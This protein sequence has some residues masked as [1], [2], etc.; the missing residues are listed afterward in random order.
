[1]HRSLLALALCAGCPT[2]DPSDSGDTGSTIDGCH[3]D[4]PVEGTP[5]DRTMTASDAGVDTLATDVDNLG[6]ALLTSMDDVP[7]NGAFSALSVMGMFS[8]LMP[9]TDGTVASDLEAVLQ[10]SQSPDAHHTALSGVL[11]E[12]DDADRGWGYEWGAGFWH[13]PSLTIGSDWSDE[14]GALYGVAP[15]PLD[16]QQDG[17]AARQLLNGWVEQHTRCLIPEFYPP[18]YDFSS[19]VHV[20]IHAMAIEALWEEPF[21][22]AF[23]T[24]RSFTLA[25]GSTVTVPTMESE[26][27]QGAEG[28]VTD[29]TVLRLPYK[30]ADIGM[31]VVMP[32]EPTDPRALLPTL[33]ADGVD[34]YVAA[35]GDTGWM[36]LQMPKWEAESKMD[37]IPPL[38][39]LG[40]EPL[41]QVP[42]PA[43]CE[44]GCALPD[45]V[46]Q[47]VIVQVD[48]KGTKAA[49]ATSGE[50]TDSV[51][52][53]TTV[54]KPFVWFLRDD[55][56]GVVMWTGWVSNPAG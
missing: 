55:V 28:R 41:I 27:F 30:G 44:G 14:V 8:V 37:L 31:Y 9:A 26:G 1:M 50:T 47:V 49:A 17:E 39:A 11:N 33:N 24:D 18:G 36:A 13:R 34:T 35:V 32:D 53:F 51:P 22:A 2:T 7:E 43:I 40:Y 42:L 4:E 45:I 5:G 21:D 46:R 16:F 10:L 3:R 15:E 29:A 6:A 19:H 52:E 20:A 54:D 25:D 12:L 23:T 48:E 38:N 56:S